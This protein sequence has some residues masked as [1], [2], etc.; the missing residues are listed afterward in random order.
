MQY[1]ALAYELVKHPI[2]RALGG[3]RQFLP[4]VD[5]LSSNA[6]DHSMETGALT[7]CAA[8]RLRLDAPKG[9][10]LGLIHDI[11]KNPLGKDGEIALNEI[12]GGRFNH[13]ENGVRK[14]AEFKMDLGIEFEDEVDGDEVD[15]GVGGHSTAL[16][17]PQFHSF[18]LETQLMI[19]CDKVAH[20]VS[21]TQ[22]ALR[23]GLIGRNEL[24]PQV[25]KALGSTPADW[26]H[27]LIDD[28]VTNSDVGRGVILLSQLRMS[29]LLAHRSW[30]Y[31]KKDI[32]GGDHK[33]RSAMTAVVK[34]LS[35]INGQLGGPDDIW[36]AALA[37]SDMTDSEILALA[38]TLMPDHQIIDD[39]GMPVW[40]HPTEVL[41]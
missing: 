6:K 8:E 20:V 21:D 32:T 1:S 30:L 10:F 3:R 15:N 18:H 39:V 14:V 11:G 13:A 38:H 29:A 25:T 37:A 12:T 34:Y 17:T 36:E 41:S 9:N 35:Q 40:I 33:R 16:N 24:E 31:G 2:F 26:A 19:V 28:I 22:D 7:T 23:A 27:I 5:T 4:H